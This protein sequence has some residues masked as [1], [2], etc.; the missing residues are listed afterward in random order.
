MRFPDLNPAIR[1]EI[2]IAIG[3][4]VL[5]FLVICALSFLYPAEGINKFFMAGFLFAAVLFPEGMHSDAGLAFFAFG[6]L[7]DLLILSLAA[8]IVVRLISIRRRPASRSG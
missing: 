8:F 6:L 1:R 3:I 2:W 7:T 4:G 5:A